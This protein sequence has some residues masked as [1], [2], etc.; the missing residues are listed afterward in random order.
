VIPGRLQLYDTLSYRP[1]SQGSAQQNG[2][3]WARGGW[4]SHGGLALT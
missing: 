4:W 3:S 2:G 1:A